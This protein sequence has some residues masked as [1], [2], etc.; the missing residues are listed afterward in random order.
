MGFAGSSALGADDLTS[1]CI[2]WPCSSTVCRVMGAA[3]AMMAADG[4]DYVTIV[5]LPILALSD[6]ETA[7]PRA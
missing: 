6:F 7:S 1:D 4:P 2:V 3:A 5:N